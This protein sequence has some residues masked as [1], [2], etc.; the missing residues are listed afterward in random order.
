V[1]EK[2][3][4]IIEGTTQVH[5][6]VHQLILVKEYIKIMYSF[7]RINIKNM[8]NKRE[9]ELI[10]QELMADGFKIRN[11]GKHYIISKENCIGAVTISC[12][13]SDYFAIKNIKS[14]INKFKRKNNLKM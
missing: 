12:T 10:I 14:D 3:I 7:I 8:K 2:T 6:L 13:P 11:G 9:V 4:I 5:T 1:L